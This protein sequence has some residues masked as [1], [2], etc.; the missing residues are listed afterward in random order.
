MLL[1]VSQ[2]SSPLADFVAANVTFVAINCVELECVVSM[3]E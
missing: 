3:T 2:S 1:E